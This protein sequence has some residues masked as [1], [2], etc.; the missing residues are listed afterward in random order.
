MKILFI[1]GSG[2]ISRAV[3]LQTIAAGHELWL[4]NRGQHRQ[5]EGARSLTADMTD[6]ASVR[7]ALHGHTWDVVVQWIAF[8]PEDIQRDVELFRDRTRQYIFIS[9]ASIYQKPPA[10]PNL[11]TEATPRENQHWEYSRKKIAAELAL[12]AAHAATNF[13]YTIVRPS[14]TYGDDQIPLVLNAWQKPW[15]MIDRLQRG[16]PLII[17]GDG[18]SLWT[19]THNTDF[20]AGLIGLF[21]NTGAIGEAVHITSDEA[22]SWNQ[23]FAITA[24]AAGITSPKFVHI[25]SDFIIACVPAVEGTLLGDKAI[26]AVFDNSK[27]K[28]LV[29]GFTAKTP[30]ATGIRRTLAWFQADPARRQIDG[31]LNQ[32]WDKLLAAYTRGL[33]AAKAEFP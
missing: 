19:I 29:P 6:L 14:L 7:A 15:T 2:V 9:S 20:A 28:R 33:A 3:T 1:G 10:P 17:P 30:F 22:L 24:D 4:L 5:V 25:A 21:G 11:I 23:Y 13:P 32:R 16:A 12:E 27:L 31:E 8:G 26:S 18:T